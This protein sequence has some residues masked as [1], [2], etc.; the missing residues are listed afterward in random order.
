MDDRLIA[1]RN[2]LRDLLARHGATVYMD[3]HDCSDFHGV[4]GEH[5]RVTFNGAWRGEGGSDGHDFVLVDY[6]M[7]I[8]ANDLKD[9]DK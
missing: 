2:D 7:S 6:G 8:D 4:T 1:F 5:M 3:A 9:D